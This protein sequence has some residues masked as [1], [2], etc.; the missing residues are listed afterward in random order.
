MYNDR[1]PIDSEKL[2]GGLSEFAFFDRAFQVFA[3]WSDKKRGGQQNYIDFFPTVSNLE[4]E[5][6][7]HSGKIRLCTE[8]EDLFGYE[9]LKLIL[10]VEG[11]D[12]LC[13]N[14]VRL[15]DLHRRGVRLLTLMWQGN[16]CAGG[17]HDT[18]NGLSEFGKQLVCE[19]IKLGIIIDLSH[20]SRSTFSQVT[21]MGDFPVVASHSNAYSI[22]PH[23]RNLLDDEF[24]E[25]VQRGGLVGIN[26]H[27]PFLIQGASAVDYTP[28]ELFDACAEH[29]IYFLSLGGEKTLALGADRDGIPHTDG[30][31][32]ARFVHKLYEK[33]LQKNI[34]EKII[35]DIFIGNAKRFFEKT[36]PSK[37]R[38]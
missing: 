3:V 19:C 14:I 10:A 4:R 24:C 12:L 15:Y 31:T 25:I 18:E 22:C 29:I 26:L 23:T 13:G 11:A 33:L 35:K 7:K 28:D 30:Y 16:N 32:P 9:K 21:E 20:A 17:A 5:I 27:A 8:K 2:D 38:I 36:L 37:G 1:L 6:E 34:D